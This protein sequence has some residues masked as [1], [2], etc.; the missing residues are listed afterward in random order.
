[1]CDVCHSMIL[2]RNWGNH[3]KKVIT[4]AD[5]ILDVLK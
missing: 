4:I 5:S 1:M 2:N 3:I